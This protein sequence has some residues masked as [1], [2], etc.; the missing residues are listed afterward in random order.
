[1]LAQLCHSPLR[2]L[3]ISAFLLAFGGLADGLAQERPPPEVIAKLTSSLPA[4]L[5]RNRPAREQPGIRRQDK[6]IGGKDARPGQFPWQ[7]ALIDSLAPAAR[8]FDG[9]YCGGTLIAW[10]WILTAAHCTFE[11]NPEGTSL[12]PVAKSAASIHVYVGSHNFSGGERIKVRRI[13]RH[14]YNFQTLENDIALLELEMEPTRKDKLKLIRF[15]GATDTAPIDIGRYVTAVGWGSTAQGV[16]TNRTASRTLQYV[17][18]IQIKA[19]E[20]CNKFYVVDA[21]TRAGASLKSLG[22]S[23]AEIKAAVD[24]W[25]PLSMQK[26]SANMMCAGTDIGAADTCFG[27]SGGPLLVRQGGDY[28]QAGIVSWGPNGGCGLA[29]LYGVYVPVSRYLDW[30]AKAMN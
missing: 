5:L 30:I 26:I 22:K 6:I 18:T 21:R 28:A 16:V 23:D 20:V 3:G 14:D 8:P 2:V 10:R 7:V 12:P 13:V 19:S 24:T 17:E 29:N 11:D 15:L 1:M 27:D 25:Y 4:S 9:F